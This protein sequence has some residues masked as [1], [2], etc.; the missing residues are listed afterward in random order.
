MG[1]G[2][3]LYG[4]LQRNDSL[5]LAHGAFGAANCLSYLGLIT[6]EIGDHIGFVHTADSTAC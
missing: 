1:N 5:P 6:A 3:E 4:A 2:L